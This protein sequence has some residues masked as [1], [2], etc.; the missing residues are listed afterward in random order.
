MISSD[1]SIDTLGVGLQ[2]LKAHLEYLRLQTKITAVIEQSLEE[3][4]QVTPKTKIIW[5]RD[6][7][8]EMTTGSMAKVLG[9]TYAEADKYPVRCRMPSPPFLFTNRIVEVDARYGDFSSP[10]SIVS[11]YDIPDDSIFTLY[12]GTSPVVFQESAHIGIFL[13]G[14]LGGDEAFKGQ[15]C[16]RITN[17]TMTIHRKLPNK[18][19][20]FQSIFTIDEIPKIIFNYP[21]TLLL[22]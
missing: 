14:L 4:T 22:N 19:E 17:N 15:R 2:Q 8:E 9:P 3:R 6:E 20:T 16:F 10:A 13:F 5:D 7:L 1:L 11:E 12:S 18:G 21:L